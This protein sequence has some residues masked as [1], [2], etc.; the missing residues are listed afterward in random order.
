[1][2]PYTYYKQITCAALDENYDPP[3]SAIVSIAGEFRNIGKSHLV[4]L[5][6]D[7]LQA[8]LLTLDHKKDAKEIAMRRDNP[9]TWHRFVERPLLVFDITKDEQK[10]KGDKV[11]LC[12]Y[13]EALTTGAADFGGP[14]DPTSRPLII[15][16]GNDH[17]TLA[18]LGN[19]SAHRVHFYKIESRGKEFT[20]KQ[21][22]PDFPDYLLKVN[23]KMMKAMRMKGKEQVLPLQPRQC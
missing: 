14:W 4:Q 6:I 20:N 15:F 23:D 11:N 9:E 10:F 16:I 22:F 19:F 8:Y 5:F 18:C 2:K 17:L 7:N 3:E 12:S 13:L 21:G 1:M